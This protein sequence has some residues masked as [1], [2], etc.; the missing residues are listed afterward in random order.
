MSSVINSIFN[1]PNVN[2]DGTP[3]PTVKGRHLIGLDFDPASTPARPIMW[4]VHS[5][6]RFCF[7]QSPSTCEV[8]PNSGILTRLVGPD[9][10]NPAN[11]TDFVTG[12]PRSRENH[13]PN[14]VHFGPDGWLYM[15][16]GSDTNYGAASTAFSGLTETLPDRLRSCGFNVNGA[17]AGSFPLD[18]RNVDTGRRSQAGHLRAVRERLSQP[19]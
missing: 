18:V 3:A 13:A 7:N 12:L 1:T 8:N 9:F 4:A 17:P 11:R 6:P 10:D 15:S 14:A 5:D 2:P 19:V 16:I